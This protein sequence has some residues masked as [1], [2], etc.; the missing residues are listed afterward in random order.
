MGTIL[1]CE[2][3]GSV[4]VISGLAIITA[5]KHIGIRFLCGILTSWLSVLAVRGAF[6]CGNELNDEFDL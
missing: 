1:Y 5:L 3:E 2:D 6:D 4:Y